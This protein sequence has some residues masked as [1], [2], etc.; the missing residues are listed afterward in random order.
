MDSTPPL[1][2]D[3]APHENRAGGDSVPHIPFTA[4]AAMVMTS[5]IVSCAITEPWGDFT[6]PAVV[7]Q[8]IAVNRMDAPVTIKMRHAYLRSWDEEMTYSE[9][10]TVELSRGSQPLAGPEA[11]CPEQMVSPMYLLI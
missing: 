10:I 8:I 7:L 11:F 3:I 1:P 9:W 4:L 2:I 5:G 6:P